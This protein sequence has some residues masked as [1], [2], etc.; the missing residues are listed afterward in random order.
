[1]K[2][3]LYIFTAILMTVFF[4]SCER[5]GDTAPAGTEAPARVTEGPTA[6]Q[7]RPTLKPDGGNPENVPPRL[8]VGIVVDQ[9]RYDFLTRFWDKYGGDGFKR[10]VEEGFS[11]GN[12][13]FDYVPTVTCSGHASVYTGTTPSVHGIIGNDWFDRS[14]GGEMYCAYDE[15]ASLVGGGEALKNITGRRS[16]RNM[17]TTTVT[18]EIKLASGMQSIV[19]GISEKDRGAIIPA[20]HLGDAAWWLDDASGEWVTSTY[21]YRNKKDATEPELPGWVKDFNA[22]NSAEKYLARPGIEGEWNTLY[23]ISSYE[24]SVDDSP[25]EKSIRGVDES[26]GEHR[27]PVFPYVFK[28][29][30]E[31]NRKETGGYY[32]KL[33]TATPFGN[34]LTKDFAVAAVEGAGLGKDGVTDFLAVSFSSTDIIGHYY[35]PRSI[36]VED[37]YL[38]LDRDVAALLESLDSLVGEGNY[39]VFLTADH[40]VVDVPLSLEEAGVPA[41]YFTEDDELIDMLNTRLAEVFGPEGKKLALAYSN[42]QVYLD[43]DLIRSKLK[44]SVAD[45]ERETADFLLTLPGVADAVT[46]SELSGAEF[47]TGPRALVENGF[48]R[49]RSGDV[50]VI[51]EPA[52]IEYKARYGKRG[53]THGAPYAYDTH[54]PLVFYGWKIRRGSS[55]RPV[56]VTDAA[57]TVS[58]L[59]GVPFPNG[60]TGQP[61]VEL[62]E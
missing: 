50:A 30:L 23:D 25:Y 54:V 45:V 29:V 18:D 34:S 4:I 40:G 37:T 46:A 42:Q 61:L 27:K 13:Q 47:T 15:T 36:E 56:S 51:M 60:A 26:T 3:I 2:S 22:E 38:R 59:L 16:P 41:G 32:G 7:P 19:V 43:R 11:Y 62:F 35:G 21:Y 20:G 17:L 33:I 31:E 5:P 55:M 24:Q 48:Y 39:L 9:M 49:K 28:D 53:T 1:M 57:P 52:W 6:K 58:A 8:V 10:L 44:A 12:A 14:L